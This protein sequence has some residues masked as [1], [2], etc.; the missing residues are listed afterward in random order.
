MK[1][2]C[3]FVSRLVACAAAS[4]P[5]QVTPDLVLHPVA[6]GQ[7]E[8]S[9]VVVTIPRNSTIGSIGVFTAGQ[10]NL[11]FTLNNSTSN[12]HSCKGGVAYA[13][14]ATCVLF[15]KFTPKSPGI[16]YGGYTLTDS[17]GA[18]LANGYLEGMGAGPRVSYLP[19]TIS[20]P[21]QQG[22]PYGAGVLWSVSADENE[23]YSLITG[24]TSTPDSPIGTW[25]FPEFLSLPDCYAGP[26]CDPN[27]IEKDGAGNIYVNSYFDSAKFIPLANGS[28][29]STPA[30]Q[31]PGQIMDGLG[32]TYSVCGTAICENVRQPDGSSILNTLAGGFINPTQVAVDSNG[33]LYVIDMAS[34]PAVYKETL[35][36]HSYLPS[37]I[38]S[39]WVNP[40]QISVDGVGNVY[41]FD[42]PGEYKAT[43]EGGG[44]YYQSKIFDAGGTAS[45]VAVSPNGNAYVSAFGYPGIN[46]WGSALLEVN[47]QTAPSLNFASTTLGKPS[48]D[49]TKRVIISNSGNAPLEISAISYP[50]D[51][52]EK[53]G[54]TGECR[55][56][57]TL[58]AG[59]SCGV[60]VNF[61]PVNGLAKGS[62]SR[63]LTEA[64][65]V[66]TNTL[67][68]PATEQSIAVSGTETAVPSVSTRT[69]LTVTPQSI[70]NGSVTLSARVTPTSGTGVPSGTVTFESMGYSVTAPLDATG[71]AQFGWFEINGDLGPGSITTGS[72]TVTALYNGSVQFRA[73]TSAP[74]TGTVQN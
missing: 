73:S 26:Y 29:Q 36:N 69:I 72:Y 5:A 6:L 15:V 24:Y 38:G 23:N 1:N 60:S 67:G 74:V 44:G 19:G 50:P 37:R 39:G 16:R 12:L 31:S 11:D 62:T 17:T 25:S 64:I 56:N 43:L 48:Y 30:Q 22:G 13:A 54:A 20:G 63:A 34:K 4:L 28:L 27:Q 71:L 8:P 59:G 68:V 35:S 51:F 65:K 2:F 21:L 9:S 52:P 10:Q 66:T 18:V 33:N 40:T 3:S 47:Y 49:G 45:V 70:D 61:V 32:N 41:V 14:D 57:T 46:I 55:S 53:M 42:S 58:A 7:S